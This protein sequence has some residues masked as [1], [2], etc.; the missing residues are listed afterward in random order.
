[1]ARLGALMARLGALMT[2]IGCEKAALD[3]VH[4]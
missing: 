2:H 4:G 3:Q 1:M